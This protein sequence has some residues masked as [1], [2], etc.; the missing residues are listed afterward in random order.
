MEKLNVEQICSI[1]IYRKSICRW[2]MYKQ[3]K[4]SFWGDTKEGFYD[5]SFGE[6]KIITKD[7]IEQDKELYCD[8]RIVFCYPHIEIKMSDGGRYEKYFKTTKDIDLYLDRNGLSGVNF[9]EL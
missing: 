4:K 5:L 7:Q 8:D 6:S 1:K 3:Y 2:Y 9:I